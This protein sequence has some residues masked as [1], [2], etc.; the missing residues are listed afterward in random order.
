MLNTAFLFYY[1]FENTLIWLIA[2]Q[3]SLQLTQRYPEQG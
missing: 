3:D 2:V 1:L